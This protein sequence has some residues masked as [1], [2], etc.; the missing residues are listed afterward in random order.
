MCFWVQEFKYSG[1][2]EKRADGRSL[3]NK[4]RKK[5]VKEMSL[6]R[7]KTGMA[8]DVERKW[9]K[10][11][12]ERKQLPRRKY[13]NGVKCIRDI[14]AGQ[15][16]HVCLTIFQF[17]LYQGVIV[18]VVMLILNEESNSKDLCNLSNITKWACEQNFE[19]T[20]L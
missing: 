20:L 12:Q 2:T 10:D 8:R 11:F 14:K 1:H 13:S 15:D 5:Q 4:D 3:R 18:M 9:E 6:P 17:Q 7:R 19:F 16:Q